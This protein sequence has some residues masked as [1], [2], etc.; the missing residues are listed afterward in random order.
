[1]QVIVTKRRNLTGQKCRGWWR[2][3]Y[4]TYG[5]AAPDSPRTLHRT[6]KEAQEGI[7]SVDSPLA[8][9]ERRP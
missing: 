3:I 2:A 9:W 8:L 5:Q 7:N 1:M 4:S 6:H